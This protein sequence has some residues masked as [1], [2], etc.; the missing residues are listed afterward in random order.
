[1]E[2]LPK[3]LW[4][5]ILVICAYI[6]LIC[7]FLYVFFKFLLV[8]LLPFGLALLLAFVLSV[9]CR[10]LRQK[11][12]FS[13]MFSSIVSVFSFILLGGYLIY[14][15]GKRLIFEARDFLIYLSSEGTLQKIVD[16]VF[17]FG[18]MIGKK[19]GL[20]PTVSQKINDYFSNMLSSFAEAV[21]GKASTFLSG[22]V[23]SLPQLFLFFVMFTV[24]SVCF[25]ADFDKICRAISDI[26]SKIFGPLAFH[27]AKRKG[28][29]YIK[30]YVLIFFLTFCELLIGTAILRVP[31]AAVVSLFCAFIDIL[32]VLGV[33]FVLIPYAAVSLIL[34]DIYR[35]A[36]LFILY[37]AITA[38]R[39][40]IEPKMV[41]RIIGV[42]TPVV[43]I[44]V[45]L[46]YALFGVFGMIAFPILFAVFSKVFDFFK[47]ANTRGDFHI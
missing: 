46:G 3:K 32:P 6:V 8:P 27:S 24:S 22:I 29:S 41:G 45:S 43:L 39:Q 9:P 30:A 15:F 42:S 28:R 26:A 10:F 12:H 13:R 40:I 21:A 5:K 38:V 33:G 7:G 4:V 37:I 2:L 36:G 34:G 16:G 35:G 18:E 1:M 31:Y 23:V 14:S 44:A 25:C 19:I 47:N 17:S 20:E 11:L